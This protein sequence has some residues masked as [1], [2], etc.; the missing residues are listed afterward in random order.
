M[1]GQRGRRFQLPGAEG[2]RRRG[3][4]EAATAHSPLTNILHMGRSTDG[5]RAE[6]AR[7]MGA[8]G[9]IWLSPPAI[10]AA[11]VLSLL[12][13]LAQVMGTPLV[14]AGTYYT[15]CFDLIPQ[16]ISMAVLEVQGIDAGLLRA[17]RG[18]YSQLRRMFKIKGCL[19]AWWVATN[20]IL[21]GRPLS[22]VVIYAM[23]TTWKRIIDDLSV[24]VTV[25]T[26]EVPP[27]PKEEVIPSCYRASYGA[28]LDNIWVWR[29]V[30]PCCC[31]EMGWIVDG[32][33]RLPPNP[34]QG[35]PGPPPPPRDRGTA[36]P[37]G[38]RRQ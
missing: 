13:E 33:H 26:K 32:V 35:G 11:T 3:P 21:Q 34:D 8:S 20:G 7:A 22:V 25:T 2:Q 29:C 10:D 19:G 12:V 15:K 17:F 9:G 28:S 36:T 1:A 30:H 27:R 6:L 38:P 37:G 5:R 18:M 24:L 23:T 4:D 14:G 16:A 31:W